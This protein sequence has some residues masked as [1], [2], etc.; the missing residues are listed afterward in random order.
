MRGQSIPASPRTRSIIRKIVRLVAINR[1]LRR[2]N[3]ALVAQNGELRDLLAEI[4]TTLDRVTA[5][6]PR[7][8][9]R[10]RVRED[11]RDASR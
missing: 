9:A 2:D 5:R 11:R 1:I 6:R 4:A 8:Q 10:S 7:W 3:E